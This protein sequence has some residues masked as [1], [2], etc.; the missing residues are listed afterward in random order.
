[1]KKFLLGTVGLVALGMASAPASAADLAARPYTKAPPAYIAPIYDWS[2][3]YIGANGGWGTSR[4]CW[5]ATTAAGTLIAAEGCHD[6]SGGTAG[7]Q[8]GYRWQAGQAV[9]GLEAQGNWADFT[10]SNVSTFLPAF[11]TDRTRIDA[12]GLFTGQIGYAWNNTLLYVKGGAAVTDNRNDIFAVGGGGLLASSG[13][14][15]RW[16]GTVGAGVEFGF[17]PNWSAGVE[18]DHL[19]MQDKNV[20][21][22]TVGGLPFGFDNTRQDVDMVTARI[23]YRIS[24]PVIGKY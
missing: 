3:F 4:N 15:T 7:G 17:A 10:G 5:D 14:Y 6:S 13:D 9:F 21:F 19:F 18:Y 23:N 12:F 22:T 24:G 8:I 20:A 1:M 16:G 11:D 2:G